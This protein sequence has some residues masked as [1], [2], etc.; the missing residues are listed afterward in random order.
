MKYLFSP[1]LAFAMV[2]AGCV[3]YGVPPNVAYYFKSKAQLRATEREALAGDNAAARRMADY[4][5]FA[6]NDRGACM[7]WFKLAAI[8]GDSVAQEN[9]KKVQRE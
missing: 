1:V 9:L 7:W 8:R 6:R 5:Y 3:H 2:F 4:Y